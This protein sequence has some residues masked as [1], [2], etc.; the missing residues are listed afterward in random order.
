M[1]KTAR[2]MLA[3]VSALIL[4]L[5]LS[6]PTAFSKEQEVVDFAT[7]NNPNPK[8]RLHL[9]TKP[10][11]DAP[12]LGK[13][14]NGVIVDVLEYTSANWVKVRIGS[15]GCYAYGYMMKN[16]LAFG[17]AMANVTSVIPL[18]DTIAASWVMRSEPSTT[19][20]EVVTMTKGAR[21]E[22][23]GFSDA[24]WHVRC[25]VWAGYVQG[26][27]GYLELVS[28]NPNFDWN[29]KAETA[30]VHNPNAKDRL[31]LRQKASTASATL[32]KYYSGVVVEQLSA[33]KNGW[34][35]VR[36]GNLEGYMQTKYLEYG[37]NAKAV[38]S[39]MPNVKIKNAGG[40]GL[41]LRE[42]QSTTAKS[43]G[44]YKN[45]TNVTV[46]GISET[47]AHVSVA[48]KTGFML[49]EWLSPK[50]EWQYG[51]G[52]ATTKPRA[53]FHAGTSTKFS[54]AEIEAA[55]DVVLKKFIDEYEANDCTLLD[56]WYDEIYSDGVISVYS[57]LKNDAGNSIVILT[58]YK[59]GEVGSAEQGFEPGFTYT[60]WMFVL[61]RPN[62]SSAW[63]MVGWGLQ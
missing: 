4:A 44:L 24:W 62:A 37:A 45:G 36:I 28:G 25:G 39:A 41:N 47:W 13:Y 12:S 59:V 26:S 3:L 54:K 19:S 5:S 11:A 51:E 48:G 57:D 21:V 15:P 49:R 46:L 33:E 31:N 10:S 32:G 17:P 2:K 14:F 55:A 29:G 9:R 53:K 34:M 42:K 6:L 56:F 23:L 43:L 50:P 63:R 7:V 1:M 58:T 38:Q 27:K 20:A 35:Q 61:N 16:Y 22:L 60:C 8:D 18:Y 40:T 30:T 52:I